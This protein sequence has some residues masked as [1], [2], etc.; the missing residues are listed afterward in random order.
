MSGE[1]QTFSLDWDKLRKEIA[2]EKAGIIVP[3]S[4]PIR[5]SAANADKKGAKKGSKA[6]GKGQLKE[7]AHPSPRYLQLCMWILGKESA[8]HLGKGEALHISGT[9]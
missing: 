6:N 9:E 1:R 3:P 7:G 5:P 2:D 8:L 4:A